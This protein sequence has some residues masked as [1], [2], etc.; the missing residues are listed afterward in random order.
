VLLAAE[1]STGGGFSISQGGGSASFSHTNSSAN[2]SYAGVNEQAGIQAG[3][4]GFDINVKGNTDLKGAVIASDAD[5]SKNTLTTGTLTFSDI[6]NHSEYSASSSGFSGGAS[7]GAPSK[8]LGPSSIGNAGGFTPMLGQHDSGSESATTRSAIG[9][10]TINITDKAHQTQDVATLSRDTADT[11]GT[12]A[13]TPDLNNLLN[14][15]A[16]MM[17]AASAAGEAVAT[18]IG[19]ISDMKKQA[20]LDAAKKADAAGDS[21]SAAEY[22]DEAAKW[23][24][25]GTYRVALHTAGGALIAGLGG[26]NALG[27]AA[28]AGVASAVAGKLN[29]LAD[30]F[31]NGNGAG[32]DPGLT[33]GNVAANILAGG[34]GTLIGGNSGGFAA[35]NADLYNRNKSN[36]EGLGSKGTELLDG[37]GKEGNLVSQVCG[38]MQACSDQT[39]ATLSHAQG[40]NADAAMG[41]MKTTAIYAVPGIAIGLLGPEALSAAALAGGMDYAGSG[42]SYLTGLSK[43]APDL[44]SS[45]I[46]GVMG[47]LTYPF[48]FSEK[49]IV[50][51]GTLGKIAANGYNAGVAGVGAFGAAGMTGQDPNVAG[52]LAAGTAAAGTFAKLKLPGKLGEFANQVIQGTAGPLQN[53]IQNHQS[54]KR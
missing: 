49:A 1:T 4:G 36:A 21:A 50:G 28:G 25:G 27:G 12:V 16:D 15:Q 44:T 31:S 22:R 18:Q 32:M 47:G 5:A 41:N 30:G 10:G 23:D 14:N 42:Y 20:A 17:G 29:S 7:V 9:A 2:G 26:G 38:G 54:S 45:Y 51:M 35:A 46:A 33:A 8:G 43:D 19:T 11:N 37:F 39:I 24:E 40:E 52:S 3:T 6:E 13:K 53:Y 34:I 48:S